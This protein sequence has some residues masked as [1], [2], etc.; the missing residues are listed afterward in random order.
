MILGSHG[1]RSGGS[2]TFAS[3]GITVASTPGNT[4][5]V[6]MEIEQS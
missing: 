5:K 6:I 1:R 2:K 4:I 3:G